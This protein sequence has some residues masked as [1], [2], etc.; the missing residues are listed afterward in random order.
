MITAQQRQLVETILAGPRIE[1]KELEAL[2]REF[3]DGRNLRRDE[4]D[5]L[6]ELFKRAERKGPGFEEYF[7]RAIENYALSQG[8]IDAEMAAWLRRLFLT[9]GVCRERERKILHEL[10]GE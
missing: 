2:R 10:R 3:G 5:L 1:S 7:Y 4:A 6:V 8:K 9:D